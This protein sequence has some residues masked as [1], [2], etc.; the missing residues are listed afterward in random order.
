MSIEHHVPHAIACCLLPVPCSPL[1]VACCLLVALH[2]PGAGMLLVAS[3]QLSEIPDNQW[4]C[5]RQRLA[6]CKDTVD[7]KSAMRAETV[8]LVLTTESQKADL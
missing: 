8:L 6:E 7:G 3:W 1:P 4:Q 5:L 2:N